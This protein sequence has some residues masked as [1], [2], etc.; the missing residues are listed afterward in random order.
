MVGRRRNLACPLPGLRPP[1]SLPA[2]PHLGSLPKKLL[3]AV[4]ARLLGRKALGPLGSVWL[5]GSTDA[6]LSVDHDRHDDPRGTD[7]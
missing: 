2:K 7:P 6:L 1:Q 3:R 5:P 4:V